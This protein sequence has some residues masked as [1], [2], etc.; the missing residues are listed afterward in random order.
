MVV[1]NRFPKAP[2][3]GSVLTSEYSIYIVFTSI[4][5]SEVWLLPRFCWRYTS[6]GAPDR[7]LPQC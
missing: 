7:L 2:R 4:F 5:R 6:L 3:L 1:S